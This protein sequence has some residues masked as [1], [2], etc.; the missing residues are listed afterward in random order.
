MSTFATIQRT[1]L[2]LIEQVQK[3]EV[4]F[5]ALEQRKAELE[6][7][8]M[9]EASPYWH[10]DKYLYLIHRS[11]DGYRARQY[12]GNDPEKI[13]AALASINRAGEH[14]ATCEKLNAIRNRLHEAAFLVSQ[15]GRKL[16]G[17]AQQW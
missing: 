5:T 14:A 1:L 16:E 6:K 2:S 13:Q 10:Q 7:Q 3:L 17:R 8:E 9:N 11:V 4:E 12:V 15:V